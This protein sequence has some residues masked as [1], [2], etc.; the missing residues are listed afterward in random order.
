LKRRREK[1]YVVGRIERAARGK[2][3]VAYSGELA[4]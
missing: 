2:P 3:T 1:F 4:L